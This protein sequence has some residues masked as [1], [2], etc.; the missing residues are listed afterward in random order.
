[1][2]SHVA[3]PPLDIKARENTKQ[4]RVLGNVFQEPIERIWQ[5]ER[6][7]A[8]RQAFESDAPAKHCAQCGLNWSY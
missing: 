2:C 6:Y 4:E 7:T 5:G 3:L 8:F 1:M